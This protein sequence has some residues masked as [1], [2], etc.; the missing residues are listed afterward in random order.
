[1]SLSRLVFGRLQCGPSLNASRLNLSSRGRNNLCSGTLFASPVTSISY[2]VISSS[3]GPGAAKECETEGSFNGLC[4][5]ELQCA[6]RRG[7]TVAPVIVRRRNNA[8]RVVE[9]AQE[10]V[11]EGPGLW[12]HSVPQPFWPGSG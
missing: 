7:A 1:M 5:A 11:T 9:A 6:P 2:G 10:E 8:R 4:L 12:F 3:E